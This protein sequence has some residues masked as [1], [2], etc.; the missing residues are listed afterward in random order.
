MAASPVFRT[1][2]QLSGIAR[3]A[4]YRSH[5]INRLNNNIDCGR[6][7]YLAPVPA[8]L[9]LGWHSAR[10]KAEKQPKTLG[11][12]REKELLGLTLTRAQCFYQLSKRLASM[13]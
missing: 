3:T 8:G 9:R 10:R 2:A 6:E 1:N 5:C 12:R 7:I 4:A 13:A 11:Q